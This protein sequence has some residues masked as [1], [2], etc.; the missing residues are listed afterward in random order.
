MSQ[1]K[2]ISHAGIAAPMLQP[3]IDTDVIMPS[4]EM[5]RVS[6]SGLADGLFSG[7]RYLDRGTET[8]RENPDFILNQPGYRGASIILA[9]SNMGCGSSREFAV[10]ALADYGIRAIIAPSFGAI[11]R[12]NCI[13]NGVLPVT[14]DEAIISGLSSQVEQDP[15]RH[16]V[17]IDL[18]NKLVQG[19][20][21]KL[22][23]FEFGAS[24]QKMLIDGLDSI[25]MT[26]KS[27]AEIEKYETAHRSR[28]SWMY[29]S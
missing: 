2:F 15:Q 1:R 14:L 29:P 4:R 5:K 13:R 26:M 12:T 23:P 6:R 24:D 8:E 10:W 7:W 11:F 9:G 22:Y 19:P 28:R 3:N 18:V 27:I 17:N 16:Q 21:G 25:D 20:N